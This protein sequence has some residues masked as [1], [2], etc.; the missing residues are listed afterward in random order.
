[1]AQ[2]KQGD[3]V[4]VHYT[5]KLEDGTVF[6]SSLKR[7]PL[8]FEIG[9]G[10]LISGFEQAVVGMSPGESRT[11]KVAVDKAY[12]PRREEMV[13]KVDRSKFPEDKEPQV[14]QQYE[15]PQEGGQKAIVMVTDVS[16]ENVTLDGNHP[17]A[18]KNLV[19][20]IRLLEIA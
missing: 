3:T 9:K 6:D 20:D 5:G 14:G 4:R 10:R 11:A 12:G 18:G 17:L 19:F 1:M 16:G 13:L 2:A 15:M 7:D 8:Q